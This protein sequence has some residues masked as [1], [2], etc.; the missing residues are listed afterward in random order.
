MG[1]V[2]IHIGYHK[3]ASGWLRR[4][5]FVDPRTGLGSIGKRG[6]RHPVRQLAGARPFE[7]DVETSRK[8]FEPL[9]RNEEEKGLLPVIAFERLSGHPISG[10]YDSK[11]IADRLIKTFPEARILVVLREQ[12]A[13]IL[14]TY[15]QY[16]REGG[17]LPLKTFINPP[18]TKS[19]RVPWFDL[20]HFEYHHLLAY[21]HELFGAD[22]VLALT[23]EQFRANPADF[24]TKIADFAGRPLSEEVLR[25][26]PFGEVA[27]RS[28]SPTAVE[29]HRRLNKLAWVADVNPS[30]V[31]TAKAVRRRVRPLTEA[32][33]VSQLG[34]DRMNE[35]RHAELHRVIENA[36]GDRYAASN[37][38]TAEL[39]DVDLGSYGWSV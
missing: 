38:I 39:T 33:K 16:I 34:T 1:P 9:L 30:P 13:I 31:F 25:S 37:R 4:R 29:L 6:T 22:R 18:V 24:V 27:N 10:G 32:L 20:R 19:L 2:L 17:P 12:R 26:L 23:Y 14:S 3:T 15:N 7:F 35:Q 8:Q 21:Y 28:P 11:Q 5:F 36:V